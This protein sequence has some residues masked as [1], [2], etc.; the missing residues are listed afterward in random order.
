[1]L[2]TKTLLCKK[3]KFAMKKNLLLF[4]AV[5]ICFLS[6]L[7]ANAQR[8]LTEVYTNVTVTKN[9]VYDSNMSWP[10]LPAVPPPLVKVGLQC[11]IYEPASDTAAARPVI[12][13]LHTGSFLP[14]LINQQTTG[15]RTDSTIV[16]MCTRFAKKGYVA[17]AMSYR[18]GWNPL[19][20]NS[21]TATSLLL[22]ATYRAIQDTRNCVRFLRQN[23]STY[24]L[25]TNRIALGGQG[26]GGYV[27]YAYAS[28]D[29]QAEIEL[30]KFSWPN[31]SPM[32][33]TVAMGDWLGIGGV[34]QLNIGGDASVSTKINFVF[35]YGGAMGD[36]SWIEAGDVPMV[37]L[38]CKLDPFA[39]YGFSNVV[40]P[41]TGATVINNAC[42]SRETQRI[43]QKLGNN[44][45]INDRDYNDVYTTRADQINEGFQALFP[46]EL[47]A[48]PQQFLNQSAPWEW[49]D[50]TTI[51]SYGAI[52]VNAHNTSMLTN[53]DMS[54]AKGKAYVD[55]IQGFVTP[56][57]VCALGLQGC[58]AKK[59][60]GIKGIDVSKKIE[61]YPNPATTEVTLYFGE[62]SIQSVEIY[63][64]NGQL[65][66]TQNDYNDNRITINRNGLPA[67]VYMVRAILANGSAYGK[68]VFE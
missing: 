34:P 20:T 19:T 36:S 13:L 66:A 3:M 31:T 65:I 57:M 62:S 15:G 28:L 4:S 7:P 5:V 40:V 17:V 55:T 14:A 33:S 42:G 10:S 29:K 1:L 61:V 21:D 25:D 68:V 67:G 32:V 50:S 44:D 43:T 59:P 46:L 38:H 47:P 23:V 63:N 58:P 24:K 8:Y 56:R 2:P 49:W 16:E 64:L 37:S 39:P 45:I 12:I 35:N 30:E 54:A 41:T 11:D 18:L 9:V 51:K 27:A 6:F 26:T 60:N 22:Q 52:G 48:G 53:P